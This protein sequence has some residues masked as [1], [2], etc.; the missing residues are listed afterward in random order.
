ME[1]FVEA[2]KEF[3]F[4]IVGFLLPGLIII[5]A[6]EFIYNISI[7]SETLNPII[8]LAIAY[9]IGYLIFALTLLKDEWINSISTWSFLPNWLKPFS[10]QRALEEL[11]QSD[12]Y[13]LASEIIKNKT[14]EGSLNLINYRSLRNIAMSASPEA[15]KK[16]YTFMFRSELFNQLHTISVFFLFSA[17]FI[18]IISCTT[19]YYSD[20]I[21]IVWIFLFLIS[22]LVLRKG[23]KRFYIIAMGIPFSLYIE[24]VKKD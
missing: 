18:D 4:D 12:T 16:I 14:S 24:K 15:D 2:I 20:N 21:G 10:F 23:W 7:D 19:K 22:A 13:L 9:V 5:I 3:F 6:G 1:K 11:S 17:I 8:I